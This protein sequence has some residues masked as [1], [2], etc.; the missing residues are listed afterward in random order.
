MGGQAPR[1][2]LNCVG[3]DVPGRMVRHL[4][5]RAP[6]SRSGPD[7][8]PES[9]SDSDSAEGEG[10]G[11]GGKQKGTE[12]GA[13]LITYGAMA[14]APL[15]LPSAAFIFADLAARG[16]WQSARAGGRPARVRG[17]RDVLALKVRLPDSGLARVL[18]R[19][20]GCGVVW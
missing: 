4:A 8:D 16:F 18:M 14:R 20:C 2:L 6:P 17:V 10:E 15:T 7:S 5:S 9:D 1:L 11:E 13:Q 19:A 12:G 3:G